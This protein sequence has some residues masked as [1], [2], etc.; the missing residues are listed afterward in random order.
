MSAL[1]VERSRGADIRAVARELGNIVYRRYVQRCPLC[2][3]ERAARRGRDRL[4]EHGNTGVGVTIDGRGWRC[5]ACHEGGDALDFVA[6]T[7]SGRRL[8]DTSKAECQEIREWVEEYLGLASDAE[9][10]RASRSSHTV[11]DDQDVEAEPNYPLR[12]SIAKLYAQL[13]RVDTVAAVRDY[14]VRRK[15]DPTAVADLGMAHAIPDR[16]CGPLPSWANAWWRTGH[17]LIVPL[18][19]VAGEVR[20]VVARYV[21]RDSEVPKSLPPSGGYE[22]CGLV[23]ACP[24][25]Q[26]LLALGTRPDWWPADRT[27]ELVIVEGEIDALA[28]STH[29]SDAASEAPATMGVLSGAWRQAHANRIP[30]GTTITI[31]TDPDEAG[32]RYSE[33]I[34]ETFA[35]RDDLILRRW[36]APRRAA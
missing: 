26:Q 12:S 19:D 17:R 1:W 29:W 23:I 22:R 33:Q 21:G 25:A 24:L 7:L 30:P 15:I 36:R 5:F 35:G 4:I 6:L 8:R 3:I 34:L 9:P 31:A 2:G 18:V 28:L 13:E 16:P 14:L 20:S 32:D 10:S 27:L 11:S